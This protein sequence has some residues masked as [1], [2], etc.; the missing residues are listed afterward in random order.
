M[1]SQRRPPS[2]SLSRRSLLSLVPLALACSSAPRTEPKTLDPLLVLEPRTPPPS[3][4]LG[5]L[6][7]SG[8]RTRQS[9]APLVR[10]LERTLGLPVEPKI[11]HAYDELATLVAEGQV[12]VGF[13]SPAAYAKA[14]ATLPAVAIATATRAG[15][16][17]YLGYVMVRADDPA[18][19]LAALAGRKVAWVDPSST[20]GY[21]YPRALLRSRGHDPNTFFGESVIAGDHEKALELLV[22][23][24]VDAAAVASGF[25]DE[26]RP[27]QAELVSKLR[28]VAKTAR[29]PLDCVVV[30]RSFDRDFALRLRKALFEL[31]D[32][33]TTSLELARDWSIHGF[34]PVRLERYDEVSRLLESSATP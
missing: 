30:H 16:P 10:Y 13:F 4:R 29:I 12:D 1:T 22:N 19:S 5:F 32:D 25:I 14:R 8:E 23:G 3:V 21:L 24:E 33:R 27:S 11:A 9:I 26:P 7:S 34:V 20:S 31:I 2:T 18:S 17:T 28:V 15:S 6:P